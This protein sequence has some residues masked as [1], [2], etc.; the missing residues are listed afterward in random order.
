[1]GALYLLDQR[2]FPPPATDHLECG[3]WNVT[4]TSAIT[5]TVTVVAS[6]TNAVGTTVTAT[7]QLTEDKTLPIITI[8]GGLLALTKTTTPVLSGTT[9]VVPGSIVTV[10]AGT[11]VLTA[12][13]QCNGTWSV[14]TAALPTGFVTIVATVK[15][16][17]GNAGTAKQTL[18]VCACACAANRS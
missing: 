2:S 11:Q 14:P 12:V 3:T 1:M 8:D 10:T 9:D 15:D 17:A 5:G 7:R 6:V 13:V 4:P 18:A 16:P